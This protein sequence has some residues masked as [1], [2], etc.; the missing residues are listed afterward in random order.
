[1]IS[2]I[3]KMKNLHDST[4]SHHIVHNKKG[5]EDFFVFQSEFVHTAFVEL[6]MAHLLKKIKVLSFSQAEIHAKQKGLANLFLLRT[7]W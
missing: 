3:L 4:I 2:A 5:L 6:T 1:M 7:V